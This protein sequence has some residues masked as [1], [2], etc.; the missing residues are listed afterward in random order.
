MDLLGR[1]YEID[2]YGLDRDIQKAKE[3]YNKARKARETIVVPAI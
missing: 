2:D 1:L 3:W